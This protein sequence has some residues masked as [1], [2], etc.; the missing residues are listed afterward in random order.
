M[1]STETTESKGKW[2][3]RTCTTHSSTRRRFGTVVV[4]LSFGTTTTEN[5]YGCSPIILPTSSRASVDSNR[6]VV[7]VYAVQSLLE[8]SF[9]P[10]APSPKGPLFP[11]KCFKTISHVQFF[12]VCR[13]CNTISLKTQSRNS[14]VNYNLYLSIIISNNLVLVFEYWSSPGI[15]MGCLLDGRT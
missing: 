14:K 3:V 6:V 12:E 8:L 15:W 9:Q 4:I 10:G 1:Y 13:V 11:L 2:S 5:H 7:R